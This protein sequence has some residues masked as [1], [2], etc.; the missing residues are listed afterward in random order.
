L[1][2]VTFQFVNPVA[3]DECPQVAISM[4]KMDDFGQ[5]EKERKYEFPSAKGN[6][7]FSGCPPG[8]VFR[9]LSTAEEVPPKRLGA[10]PDDF[11]E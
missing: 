1:A 2:A 3:C 8:F 5:K 6:L 7:G 9:D 10:F 11:D 4:S